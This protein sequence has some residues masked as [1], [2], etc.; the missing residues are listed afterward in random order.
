MFTGFARPAFGSIPQLSEMQARY[1]AALMNGEVQLPD[2]ETMVKDIVS[3][4]QAELDQHWSA[5]T[6]FPL[7]SFINYTNIMA[8]KIGAQVDYGKYLF[9]D[10][11]L[12][13]RLVLCQYTVARFSLSSDDPE[14]RKLARDTIMAY[15]MKR[16]CIMDMHVFIVCVYLSCLGF[17]KARP[18]TLKPPSMSVQLMAWAVL[19]F[20]VILLLVPVFIFQRRWLALAFLP[21]WFMLVCPPLFMYIAITLFNIFHPVGL[22]RLY[23]VY[24]KGVPDGVINFSEAVKTLSD[25]V[26][27]RRI[28]KPM[29]I[30]NWVIF[31]NCIKYVVWISMKVIEDVCGIEIIF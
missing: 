22:M 17:S 14:V 20:L 12:F 29:M 25:P 11:K 26:L 31:T 30:M 24:I 3:E 6:I 10:F 7:V 1:Y 23:K 13:L 15:K 4:G 19:P 28:L 5:K 8:E 27:K 18:M 16:G 2:K 9:T 21:P